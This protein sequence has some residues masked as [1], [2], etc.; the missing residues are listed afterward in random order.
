MNTRPRRARRSSMIRSMSGSRWLRTGATMA[1]MMRGETGLGPGPMQKA[2]DVGQ[3][4]VGHGDQ[5]TVRASARVESV[6]NRPRMRRRP[7]SSIGGQRPAWLPTPVARERHRRL[8]AGDAESGGDRRRERR[9]RLLQ[10]QRL[11]V[12]PRARQLVE[13]H[14][15]IGH[16]VGDGH[17]RAARRRPSGWRRASARCRRRRGSRAARARRDRRRRRRRRSIP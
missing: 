13:P 6:S 4:G 1:R 5:L 9:Q 14:A 8:Q 11:V 17:D 10:R 15:Q 12:A 7:S 3:W 2:L 16:D